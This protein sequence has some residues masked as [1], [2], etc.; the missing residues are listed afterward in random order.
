[1]MQLLQKSHHFFLDTPLPLSLGTSIHH[2]VHELFR[3][4]FIVVFYIKIHLYYF[5]TLGII[6]SCVLICFCAFCCVSQLQT[7]SC[8]V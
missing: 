5:L 2:R 1:M 8:M 3:L 6:G 7:S 4:H